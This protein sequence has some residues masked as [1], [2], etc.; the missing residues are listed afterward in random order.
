MCGRYHVDKNMMQT[1]QED[2]GLDLQEYRELPGDRE[3]DVLP[4]RKAMVLAGQDNRISVESMTWGVPM[5]ERDGQYGGE[6]RK[7]GLLIN[8]RAESALEKPMFRDSIRSRRCILPAGCFYEWDEDGN[9]AEFSDKDSPVLYMAGFYQYFQGEKRFVILTTGA[10]DSVRKTH[11]RMPVLLGKTELESWIFEDDFLEYV[12][13]RVP[14]KL[15][16]FQEY[17]QTTLE[18]LGLKL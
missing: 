7:K 9:R 14:A 10:N 3:G 5:P 18:D 8:A 17:E 11:D 13:H 4:S 12:L 15:D 6:R 2:T 1:L 16:K